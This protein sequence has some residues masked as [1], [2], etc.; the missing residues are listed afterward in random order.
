VLQDLRRIDSE[1]ARDIRVTLVEGMQ[2]LGNFDARLRE[3][4][5]V[6]LHNQGVSLVKVR[7]PLLQ[8][9]QSCGGCCSYL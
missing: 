8:A 7:L 3:Y 5:A 2:I 1:R 4:A 9:L 6:K